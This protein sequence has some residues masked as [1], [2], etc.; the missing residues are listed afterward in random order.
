DDI[1]YEIDGQ[2]SGF[3]DHG[4]PNVKGC[5]Q[6]N[7]LLTRS[8][9]TIIPLHGAP[10]TFTK[11]LISQKLCSCVFTGLHTTT[12]RLSGQNWEHFHGATGQERSTGDSKRSA[13]APGQGQ[14][15]KIEPAGRNDPAP[16]EA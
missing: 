2:R 11:L 4:V 14:A 16:V 9:R 15:P 5:S 3:G 1:G 6:V 7:L 12:S 8:Q 10:Y 13:Q